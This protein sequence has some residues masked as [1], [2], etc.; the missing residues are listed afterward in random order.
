MMNALST[1]EFWYWWIL[2][3]VFFGLEITA[4]GAFL[5]WLGFAATLTGFVSWALPDL[6]SGIQLGLFAIFS[7]GLVFIWYRFFKGIN[8]RS[9]SPFLNNRAAGL[10]GTQHALT[11]AIT[12]GIG[13]IKVHDS[14]WT[15]RGPDFPKGQTVKVTGYNSD[16]L[17]VEP[18]PKQKKD[19]R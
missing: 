6:S 16:H 3:T 2:A 1:P 10:V 9:S 15:V 5:L 19:N 7:L 4:P 11:Q 13:K 14:F 12:D 17:I 18:V 8:P